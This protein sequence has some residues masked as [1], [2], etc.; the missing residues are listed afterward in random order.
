MTLRRQWGSYASSPASCSVRGQGVGRNRLSK[1]WFLSSKSVVNPRTGGG[2]LSNL[3]QQRGSF[4]Q[5][6]A[7]RKVRIDQ[8]LLQTKLL[9]EGCWRKTSKMSWNKHAFPFRPHSLQLWETSRILKC[10]VKAS[11]PDIFQRCLV[12]ANPE[13]HASADSRL[14]VWGCFRPKAP[15]FE[16]MRFTV[17]A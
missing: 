6:Q 15:S 5:S 13:E 12:Q 3:G 8:A 1:P 10:R 11:H 4:R 16:E 17:V 7:L 14:T 2:G 9:A